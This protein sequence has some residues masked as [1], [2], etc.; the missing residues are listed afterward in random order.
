M[1]ESGGLSVITTL[2]YNQQK[3]VEDEVKKGAEKN[4]ERYNA[5]NASLVAMNV[6]TGEITAMVGSAD[7]FNDDIDGAVNI[8]TSNR[9]PGS[10]F[11]PLVY[12]AAFANGYSPETILFDTL[13]TFKAEPKDYE[14]HNYNE[15]YYGPVS[16]KKALAGSLNIPAVKAMYLVGVE[17]ILDMVEQMGYTTF[18]DR[19]RFGLSVVLGG[20]EVKLLEHTAGFATLA[21][22]GEYKAPLAIL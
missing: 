7:Y 5:H 4:S 10:S 12:S 17:N 19:S 22:E 1:L 16:M 18:E 21:D 20:G 14:P 6:D 2:D 9:Q 8:A 13:T 11:K 15:Q 3:I